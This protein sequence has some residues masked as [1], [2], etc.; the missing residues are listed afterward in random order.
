MQAGECDGR[1][2]WIYNHKECGK[3]EGIH[4]MLLSQFLEPG[5]L[6]EWI[7]DGQGYD[8]AFLMG[9]ELSHAQNTQFIICL[10]ELLTE[11][12]LQVEAGNVPDWG[13]FTHFLAGI[14]DGGGHRVVINC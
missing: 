6:A 12:L 11:A 1:E 8:R 10:R 2:M 9:R 13:H 4:E 14:L 7:R 5:G 3:C